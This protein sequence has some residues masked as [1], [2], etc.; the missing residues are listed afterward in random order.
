MI[1]C[2]QYVLVADSKIVFQKLY[3]EIFIL[4]FYFDEIKKISRIIIRKI[5]ND[6]LSSAF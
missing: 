5:R 3:F 1:S 2:F 6:F 4:I